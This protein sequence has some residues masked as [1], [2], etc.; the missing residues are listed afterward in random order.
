MVL[1]CE[2]DD[3]EDN[4]NGIPIDP[5]PLQQRRSKLKHV[6]LYQ[7]TENPPHTDNQTESTNSSPGRKRTKE[8]ISILTLNFNFFCQLRM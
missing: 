3:E 4:D 1:T 7:Q 6:P 2:D 8:Q 5:A